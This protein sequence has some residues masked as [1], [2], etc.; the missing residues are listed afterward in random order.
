M[1]AASVLFVDNPV[2]TGYSYTDSYGALTKDVAMVASDM[3]V[4]LQHFFSKKPEFQVQTQTR[5]KQYNMKTQLHT[6]H[7]T[8]TLLNT[9]SVF[10]L[11]SM[12]EILC[13]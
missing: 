6:A 12:T 9:G 1:N 7:T 11:N 8:C 4:L 13:G 5:C 10:I 2:G 3:M